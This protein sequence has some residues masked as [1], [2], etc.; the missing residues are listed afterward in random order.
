MVFVTTHVSI[1]ETRGRDL[2]RYNLR[3]IRGQFFQY[4]CCKKESNHKK[5]LGSGTTFWIFVISYWYEIDH[6]AKQFW[7]L[8][9]VHRAHQLSPVGCLLKI[10]MLKKC[11]FS[12]KGSIDCPMSKE[13]SLEFSV[14]TIENYQFD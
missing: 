8:F 11:Y 6:F 12:P 1:L 13:Q 9:F 3:E 10:W 4:L 14:R 5:F 7:M 2:T